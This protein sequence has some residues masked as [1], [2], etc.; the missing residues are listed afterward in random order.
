MHRDLDNI[1]RVLLGCLLY[2]AGSAILYVFPA[3]L[4]ALGTRLAINEAQ[5]GEVSAAENI[6]I[7]RATACIS[8]AQVFGFAGGAFAS[9]YAIVSL[10]Y[11]AL[12]AIVGAFAVLGLLMF[13]SVFRPGVVRA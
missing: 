5:Q 13:G 2:M 3:D 7:G 4:A 9:G 11:G 10:G 6:G 12:T 1:R 8:A